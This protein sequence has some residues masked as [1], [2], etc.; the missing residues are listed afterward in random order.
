MTKVKLLHL[1]YA[2]LLIFIVFFNL[3]NIKALLQDSKGISTVCFFVDT[4]FDY[5][6]WRSLQFPSYSHDAYAE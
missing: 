4:S 6:L 3:S 5:F 2:Q 1:S